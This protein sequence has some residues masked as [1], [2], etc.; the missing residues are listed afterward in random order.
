MKHRLGSPMSRRSKVI[1]VDA[2]EETVSDE[3]TSSI[4]SEDK[5]K[6]TNFDDS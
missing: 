1:D 4:S 6:W 3:K 5:S 2:I